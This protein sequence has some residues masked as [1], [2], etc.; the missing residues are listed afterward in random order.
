V[1]FE[2]LAGLAEV[3]RICGVSKGTALRYTRRTDFPRPVGRIAASP[4]WRVT[5][6]KAWAERTLPLKRGRPRSE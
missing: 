6:V 3:A 5:D 2:E 4:I 1:V